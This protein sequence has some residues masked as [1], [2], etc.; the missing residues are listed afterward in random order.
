MA[1]KTLSEQE[2]LALITN[3]IQKA[4]N[5]FNENGNGA[6]LWGAV[7][8]LCG[9]LSA[10]KGFLKIDLP[11]DPWLLTLL[12][13]I[14]QFII[15]YKEGKSNMVRSHSDKAIDA[16]WMV[17]GISVFAL[18]AYFNII[19]PQS[20]RLLQDYGYEVFRKEIGTDGYE[21]MRL[22]P[23]SPISLLILL[24]AIPTLI[25]GITRSFRPMIVGGILCYLFFV[26]SLFTNTNYDNLLAGI[27]AIINWLIPGLI[28]R[29]KYKEHRRTHV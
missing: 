8:G 18:V 22:F 17:Y 27:S 20:E 12:A 28:M 29:K 16:V 7:V 23:L 19:G 10:A 11:F 6:M 1:D 9:L 2:S 21:P 4:R 5:S 24:F 26:I 13:F 14:P 3:M 25:T 15:T